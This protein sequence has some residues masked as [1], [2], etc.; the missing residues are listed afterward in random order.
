MR[1]S[2]AEKIA[3]ARLESDNYKFKGRYVTATDGTQVRVY[4]LLMTD[5]DG[6]YVAVEV[7][8][9]IGDVLKLNMAQV[10]F[11]ANVYE[12]GATVPLGLESITVRRVI[13]IGIDFSSDRA[14]Q[15]SSFRLKTI[16]ESSGA[17]V[18]TI[19]TGRP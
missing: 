16:L 2:D 10:K 14:A 8:S 11:D 18:R 6:R 1:G 12:Y 9:T 3:R 17:D 7:K 13:Y 19:R 5:P 15:F 4:D